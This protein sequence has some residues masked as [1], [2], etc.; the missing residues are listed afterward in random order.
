MLILASSSPRRKE[1]LDFFSIPYKQANPPFDED[2][3][4]FQG[5]PKALVKDLSKGKALSLVKRFPKDIILAA[6]TLVYY[7]GSILGKPKSV[8]DAIKMLEM[9][10]GKWHQVFTGI[11]V[12]NPSHQITDVEESRILFKDCS[13]SEIKKYVS[14]IHCLDKAG[15]YAIQGAGNILIE[16]MEGCFYNTC[17]LPINALERSLKVLGL[18]LWNYLKSP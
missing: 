10:Q 11:T 2:T 17:G 7:E 18:S 16:K 6:D 5:D 8:E 15:S 3:L 4:Q 12:L 1:I 14:S 9:L 13:E